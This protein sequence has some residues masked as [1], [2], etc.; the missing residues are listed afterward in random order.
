MDRLGNLIPH[1][2]TSTLQRLSGAGLLGC[3]HRHQQVL[4]IRGRDN[5]LNISI[6]QTG[7]RTARQHHVEGI[8]HLGAQLQG[9][10]VYDLL[11]T[12]SVPA[13]V[14][15]VTR[16]PLLAQRIFWRFVEFHFF[17]LGVGKGFNTLG[18][19]FII[20]GRTT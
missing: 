12:R 14:L 18:G 8:C 5:G 1:S 6:P 3:N 10:A 20:L 2:T 4:R 7:I 11:T 16:P 13:G 17:F 9:L 19:P 15:A